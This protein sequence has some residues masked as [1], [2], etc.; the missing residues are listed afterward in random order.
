M[1]TLL[2]QP[3]SDDE[4]HALTQHQQ[5]LNKA[6]TVTLGIWL[7]AYKAGDVGFEKMMQSTHQ[8]LERIGVSETSKVRILGTLANDALSY[9]I[10]KKTRGGTVKFPIALRKTAATLVELVS[11]RE[12][13]PRTRYAV[14]KSAYERVSEILLDAGFDVKPSTIIKWVSESKNS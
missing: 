8:C 14:T 11:T 7:E 13:L 1:T 4:K 3:M 2:T 10:P 9:T 6:Q 5:R 12:Q